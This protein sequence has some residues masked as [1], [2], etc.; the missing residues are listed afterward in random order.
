M[1]LNEEMLI[2]RVE[3]IATGHVQVRFARVVYDGGGK[4]IFNGY[5]RAVLSPHEAP[6]VALADYAQTIDAWRTPERLADYDA[7]V[8]HDDDISR[9]DLSPLGPVALHKTETV[10]DVEGA[11][12][13]RRPVEV[14]DLREPGETPEN[15]AIDDLS[16]DT[17]VVLLAHWSTALRAERVI[18]RAQIK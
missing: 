2:N 5:S 4:P 11:P 7:K 18:T 9:I 17:Q 1:A 10:F 13:G 15:D 3:L 8:E 14:K 16:S 12:I 6:G